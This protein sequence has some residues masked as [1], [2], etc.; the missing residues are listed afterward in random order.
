MKSAKTSRFNQPFLLRILHGV[1]GVSLIAAI[2]TAYWTYD[3]YDGRWGR[4]PL[5][6]FPE[7]EG[8]HGTFGLWTLL[9]FPVFL[10]YAVHR[11]Q[12]RL[13]QANSLQQLAHIGHPSWWYTLNRWINTVTLALLTF[14]LFSGKMM[15][16]KWLPNGELQHSWYLAHLLSWLLM[17][18]AIALHLVVNFK[19]GGALFLLSMWRW[20]HHRSESPYFWPSSIAQG[21]AA[22]QQGTWICWF[23]P[24]SG[25][26]MMELSILISLA[27]AWILPYF[28]AD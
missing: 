19:V 23:Q 8:I 5:P 9:I 12:K 27:V 28:K 6:Q 15:D 3:T 25:L 13:V 17:V 2:L 11:G 10:I 18:G 7:I 16:E 21:W 26:M 20:R 24:L 1:T 22:I 14:A 4:I